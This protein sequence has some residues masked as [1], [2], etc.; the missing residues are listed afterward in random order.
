METETSSKFREQSFETEAN[1]QILYVEMG[2]D[3]FYNLFL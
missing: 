1:L 3:I 2:N